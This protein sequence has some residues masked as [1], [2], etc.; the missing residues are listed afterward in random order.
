MAKSN[1]AKLYE[2]TTLMEQ[3]G[4]LVTIQT[5]RTFVMIAMANDERP[6]V[7]M[8]ELGSRLGLASSTRTNVV[9]ALSVSRAGNGKLPGLDLILTAPDPDD[10]RAKIVFLTPKGRRL[11]ASLKNILEV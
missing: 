4:P 9:K 8:T 11:W 6:G 3:V 1:S 10:V 5:L 7:N 2:L